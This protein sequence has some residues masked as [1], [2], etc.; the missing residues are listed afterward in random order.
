MALLRHFAGWVHAKKPFFAGNPCAGVKELVTDE[1]AWKGLDDTEVMRLKSAA[2]QLLRLKT[3]GDQSAA[4]DTAVFLVLLHTGLRV[5]K[6]WLPRQKTAEG[7]KQGV[8]KLRR[9]FRQMESERIGRTCYY[10]LSLAR[11]VPTLAD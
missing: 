6:V 2:E 7:R 5:P 1:P 11:Q 4:R 9:Y 8:V 10:G 3:R